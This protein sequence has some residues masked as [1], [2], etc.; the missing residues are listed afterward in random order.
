MP[1]ERDREQRGEHQRDVEQRPARE[2]DEDAEALAR[3]RP[4]RR[5]SR[6]RPRASRRPACRRGWSAGRPGSRAWSGP[7]GGV[8]RRLRPSSSSRGVDRADADHRGDGDRE[9]HDQRADDDLAEQPG[10]E[11]QREQR[12]EGE[13]RD[14][15]G[16]HEVR[17]GEALDERAPR[18]H[19]AD[20]ER[21]ARPRR[22]SPSA[23]STSVVAKCGQIVP[24]GQA[25][26][27]TAPATVSGGG[28]MNGGQ[29]AD[30]RRSPARP[31]RRRR[32]PRRPGTSRARSRREL[33]PRRAD[34]GARRVRVASV[35]VAEV[36]RI[37]CAVRDTAAS[38]RSAIVRGRG[39]ST[40]MSADDPA[41]AR[42]QDDDPV[43]DEDRLGDAVGDHAR[44]SS[45]HRSQSRSSSRSNR[46]RV[47]ASSAL[48]GSSSSRTS[49]SSASARA[50]ATRWRVPPDSSDGRAAVTAGSRPTSSIS[51]AEACRPALGGPAGELERV[52]DVVGGR[53]PRQQPRL[54]ED[55]PD[56][57]GPGR[58]SARRRACAVAAGRREQAGDDPQERAT[59][60]SRWGR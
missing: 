59:C 55:E 53:P 45:R 11:P 25:R 44:W 57:A 12:G 6:R 26:R 33:A 36:A 48:N 8:A 28:R 34:D 54:L 16:G 46:S 9:E 5:R 2:V 51:V 14:R 10:P 35:E 47:S 32:T 50:S 40:G 39:R 56:R 24:S 23:T 58:R 13:D 31:A 30:Q 17:R 1:D 43:G 7:G 18:E 37:S 19:V 4:T 41:R 20:D 27:R 3:R 15:L 42:R 49:G 38:S 52:G 60:R 22:R 29:P 21:R